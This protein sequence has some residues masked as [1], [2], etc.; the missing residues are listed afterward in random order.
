MK[1]GRPTKY[2]PAYCDVAIEYLAD[3]YSV[4]AL[5]GHI[6]VARSTVFKW[7]DENPI[8]SDALRTGQAKAAMWWEETLRDVA[9]NGQ[10][11]ASAAIFGVKNRSS[12]NWKDKQEH[13]LTSSDGSMTPPTTFTYEVIKKDS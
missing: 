13:D 2:D 3:G 9:R 12:E 1:V 4:T 6:G 10:G 11:N 7:A 5:A 8:F